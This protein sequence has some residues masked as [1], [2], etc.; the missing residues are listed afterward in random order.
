M[1]IRRSIRNPRLLGSR[2]PMQP[3]TPHR[4]LGQVL[5]WSPVWAPLA[6]ALQ[7]TV[8]GLEPARAERSRLESEVPGVVQRHQ[9]SRDK[10]ARLEAEASAWQD[11]VYVERVRR[12]RLAAE[13][14]PPRTGDDREPALPAPK[15]IL[16]SGR[17]AHE[18]QPAAELDQGTLLVPE[19]APQGAT[20]PPRIEAEPEAPAGSNP[21]RTQAPPRAPRRSLVR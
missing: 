15:V 16:P 13:P 7:L 9:A 8:R 11:P 2:A 5:W 21:S 18:T 10:V 17:F 12:A 14:P 19:D 6:L 3:S 4:F 1:E 20:P